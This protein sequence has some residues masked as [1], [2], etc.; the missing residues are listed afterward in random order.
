MYTKEYESSICSY[1]ILYNSTIVAV[2]IILNDA[3]DVT[4]FMVWMM[5]MMNK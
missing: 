1:D 4:A 5:L 2:V 3:C